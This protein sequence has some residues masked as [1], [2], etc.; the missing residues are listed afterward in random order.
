MAAVA[1]FVAGCRNVMS[2]RKMIPGGDKTMQIKP[3]EIWM[4][5][6]GKPINAH[7]G[8][9]LYD[10]GVYYWYGEDKDPENWYGK[11]GGRTSWVRCYSSKNLFIWHY[12]G[13]VLSAVRKEG[14]DL[15]PGR[16][17]ERP[18]VLFNRKT[19]KYVMWM[20]IDSA[21][22]KYARTG[23]A[24]SS[25]AK[26]PFEYV[27]SFRPDE[28][29]SRDMTV[30]QDDDGTAYLF[31][32]SDGNATLHISRLSDDY[33]RPAGKFIRVFE[34]RYREAPAVFKH[35]GRYYIVSSHCTGWKPNQAEYAVADSMMGEWKVAG[36]PSAGTEE[37]G[38]TTFGSQSTYVLPVP[39]R[40][41]CFVF[42]ADRW[43]ADDLPDSRYVWLP[44]RVKPDAVKIFWRDGWD[45]SVFDA[46]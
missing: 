35:D 24:V 42:L 7:G 39:G 18:K 28:S 9:I 44:L 26:G 38:K 2:E 40:P 29:E 33:L 13:T 14:H 5:D 20:H 1:V 6:G 41:G 16:V 30:W 10:H 23:V 8:G 36:D 32:S 12:E 21:N 31:H 11:G 4:D 17:V 15:A 22:Y 27:G 45:F 46:L 19:G 34:G 3:G 25:S 37:Q 43:N